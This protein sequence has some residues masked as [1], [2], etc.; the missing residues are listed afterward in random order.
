MCINRTMRTSTN[1]EK[2][3]LV[4]IPQQNSTTGFDFVNYQVLEGQAI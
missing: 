1:G 2:V 3:E 4:L